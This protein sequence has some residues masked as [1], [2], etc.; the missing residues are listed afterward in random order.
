[1]HDE[2][3]PGR[4]T[5]PDPGDK[6]PGDKVPGLYIHVPFCSGKCRYCDFYSLAAAGLIPSWLE[7]IKKEAELYKGFGPFNSLYFGGGTPSCLSEQELGLLFKTVRTA[8]DFLPDTEITLEANPED[9]VPGRAEFIMS[10][11]INRVSLGVQSTDQDR[12]E[13]LGRRHSARQAFEAAERFRAAGCQNL[14]LDLM[15]GLPGQT[16]QE[17]LRNLDKA[18]EINPEHLSCYQLTIEGRT[19]FSRLAE[20]GELILPDEE[21]SRDLFLASSEHLEKNGYVHY[22]VSNFAKGRDFLSR[23]NRKYWLG[24][25]YLGLGPSAHSYHNGERWW[26]VRSLKKY[27]EM[28]AKGGSPVEETETLTPEQARLE[29]VFLGLRNDSGIDL[30]D[31][32]PSPGAARELERI[33][34]TGSGFIHQGRLVLTRKGLVMAD[35]LAD[36]L[37]E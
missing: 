26:N 35:R 34:E 24:A 22:E 31:L 16:V 23:H 4:M 6:V 18:L 29:A 19:Y 10:L 28:L 13:W 15:Y 1:M 2:R 14:G 7:Y 32:S 9:I 36:L 8:F 17:W 20:K 37:T 27:R 11:G 5:A 3:R 30:S 21:A 12:L 25:S 33:L